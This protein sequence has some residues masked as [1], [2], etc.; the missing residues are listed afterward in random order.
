MT[1]SRRSVVAC[2]SDFPQVLPMRDRARVI[3]E[4]LAD[5]LNQVLPGAMRETEIDMW[6]ILC[7]EDNLDPVY[8]TMIPMDT[9]CPILQMLVFHDRG[10][11]GVEG[12]NICGTDTGDLYSHP[13]RGQLPEKQWPMLKDL[14]V[15]RDPQRIGINTGRVQWAAGGLTQ[16]LHAQLVEV[17]P[18]RYVQ[19]LVCAEPLATKW[20]ATL[21]DAEVGLYEHVVDVARH[22]IAQ[23]YSRKAIVPNVTT[24]EDLKWFYWQTCA[25]L[26]LEVAFRPFFGIRRSPAAGERYGDDDRVIRPGD[27][28]HC[29]VGIKYLRLNTDHQQWAYVLREGEDDAPDGAQSLMAEANRLQDVFMSEFRHGLTG[30]ELLANILNRARA[31]GI[32]NPRVYSHSLGLL[33]HEPGP[34]IGLPWEQER[35]P[36]RGDVALDYGNAF[37][38][39]LS[40][41]DSLAEWDGAELRLS[42]EEDVV[43]GHHGCR[44]IAGRQTS[45]HL[46]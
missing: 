10:E 35:N 16:N 27:F 19:R 28:L 15:E 3:Y 32:P 29:D 21:T 9:W 22:I 18:D 40:V 12:I 41:T 42:I 30:D 34:L 36:G 43:F 4:S 25:D 5:R 20:L 11:E 7:Q 23:C 24:I 1:A 26:G 8:T 31:E 2:P 38:M 33:L 46:V 39:E 37:T 45:F 17:L 44:P 14:V 6:I 13:Y